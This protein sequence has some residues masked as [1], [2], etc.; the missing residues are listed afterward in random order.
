MRSFCKLPVLLA[1]SGLTAMA[2]GLVPV[3]RAQLAGRMGTD[4]G[5]LVMAG[6]QLVFVDEN[7]PSMSFAIPRSDISALGLQNG[8]LTIGLNQPFANSYGSSNQAVIRLMDPNSPGLI[9][10]W[11]GLPL[12]GGAYATATTGDADRIVGIPPSDLMLNVR[13]GDTSGRLIVGATGL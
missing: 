8:V 5:F 11:A 9:A 13:H 10:S 2:A 12:S 6:G 1:L 7:N 3:N 4:S